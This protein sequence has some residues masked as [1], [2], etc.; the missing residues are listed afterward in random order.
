MASMEG[1]TGMHF[2]ERSHVNSDETFTWEE[3]RAIMD[4]EIK[5]R[6][7]YVTA[8]VQ[9][10]RDR[11]GDGVLDIAGQAIYQIGYQKGKARSEMAR[12]QGQQNDLQS[13]SE[14]VAHRTAKL[15]LGTR[16]EV[17]AERMT[18]TETYCPMPAYWK[19]IGFTDTEVRRFCWM[20]DQVDRG[21]VEG[22]N[23]EFT[24]DLGGAEQLAQHG[25]CQMIVRKKQA[26]ES[27]IAKARLRT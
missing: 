26:E 13:L 12:G 27:P 9:A 2:P 22:Y 11:F 18:S 25:Y 17:E 24:A 16:V 3:V 8:I 19:S 15:Y 6:G 4:K 14:L 21:M 20:F 1:G 5:R 23:P 10:M 7:E